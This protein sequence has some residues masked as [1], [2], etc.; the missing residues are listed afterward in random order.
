[1]NPS[2]YPKCCFKQQRGV[3]SCPNNKR[4]KCENKMVDAPS[5][6]ADLRPNFECYVNGWPQ[7]CVVDGTVCPSNVPDCDIDVRSSNPP[8]QTPTLEPSMNVTP[9]PTLQSLQG[10][11]ILKPPY[12]ASHDSDP[13]CG[14]DSF[15]SIP[16]AV[17]KNDAVLVGT[18]E[19]KSQKECSN[20][21]YRPICGCDGRTYDNKCHAEVA[22]VNIRKNGVCKK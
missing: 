14:S 13:P 4:P 7:C 6:C 9:T 15:C 10:K 17:C 5:Y 19:K 8:S 11:C 3:G 18:C 21:K 12:D 2:G 1:M 16:K 22:G 20:E